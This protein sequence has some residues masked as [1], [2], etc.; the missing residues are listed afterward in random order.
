[1]H[2]NRLLHVNTNCHDLDRSKN[3]YEQLVLQVMAPA[4]SE[5][6]DAVARG[7]VRFI[8]YRD[9]DGNTLELAQM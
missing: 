4:S 6:I 5:G 3:L 2:T 8:Y 1:M 9:L 7:P